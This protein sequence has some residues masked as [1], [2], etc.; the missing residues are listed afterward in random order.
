[1]LGNWKSTFDETKSVCALLMDSVTM[2]CSYMKNYKQNF[3]VNNGASI[4][5]TVNTTVLWGSIDSLLLFNFLS[6]DSVL[7]IQY[8]SLDIYVGVI[9][10]FETWSNVKSN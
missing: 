3:L 9:N 6:N 8:S 5:Q 10:L 7:F 2:I 4:T 1:M